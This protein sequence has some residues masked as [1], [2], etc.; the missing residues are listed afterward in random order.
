MNMEKWLGHD[1]PKLGFGFMR[2]PML[3]G[4]TIDMEQTNRM[5]DTFLGAG[6]TYFDTA[7]GYHGGLSEPTIRKALVERHPRDS[8]QLATKLPPWE[9]KVKEDM[10]R[11]F[12]TQLE[13]TG[14]GYFDFYLIHN[15]CKGF[16]ET[17]DGL[18]VW[19]FLREK[20]EKGLVRHIGFS[21]HDTA[22]LLDQTLTAHPEIEFV[23]LQINYADWE[24]N[25]VQS[26][27]CH[28]VAMRHKVSVIIMEP[29]KGGALAV[30]SDE[31]RAVVLAA[32]PNASPASWA[33][34]YAAS[35]P[36]IVT[37]LSGMSN[38]EQIED[39]IA[40]MKDF[41]PLTEDEY[42]VIDKVRAILEATPTIPCTDCRYCIEKC[43]QNIPIP[44]ILSNENARRIYGYTNK[45]SY[46][47]ATRNAG[48]ASECIA[49]GVCEGRCPQHIGIIDLMKECAEIYEN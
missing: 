35:L 9:L 13:R 47:F 48:K 1:I 14:A 45:G 34:R 27:L 28:E 38:I 36:H 19:S 25:G 5:V 46:G 22:E 18:D 44:R 26:R 30:L 42:A 7:Y 3:E 41:A 16:L 11:I 39:N 15:V 40:T 20:K 31:A 32:K 6:F 21:F 24:S 2:L 4:N 8:F 49:C 12:T 17:I 10:E 43:P 37:V 23:Q 33:V 29:V